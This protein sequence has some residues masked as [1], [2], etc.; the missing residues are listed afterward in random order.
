MNPLLFASNREEKLFAR[1]GLCW[2]VFLRHSERSQLR[3]VVSSERNENSHFEP[4]RASNE[5]SNFK[6][7]KSLSRR[8]TRIWETEFLFDVKS[9]F[10][11]HSRRELTL[12]PSNL[13]P[14]AVAAVLSGQSELHASLICLQNVFVE[15]FGRHSNSSRQIPC[16]LNDPIA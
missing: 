5:D 9:I 15:L 7:F 16:W 4:A 3:N 6:T 8:K 14:L 11:S 12:P 13:P 1:R 10:G 2:V